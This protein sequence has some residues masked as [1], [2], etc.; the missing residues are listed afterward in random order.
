MSENLVLTKHKSGFY[1]NRSS[2]EEYSKLAQVLESKYKAKCTLATSGMNAINN[3][4][5]V[6]LREENEN[7]TPINLVY[8]NELY[9]DSPRLFKYL[10]TNLYTTYSVDVTESKSVITLFSE[11]CKDKINILFVEACTNPSGFIFDFSI[12]DNLR[13]LS[14]KLYVIVDN[15][16]L[17]SYIFN[18]LDHGADIVVT[19]LTKYYGNGSCIAGAI[20]TR[21]IELQDKLFDY[22]R[23]TGIHVSP[24]HCSLI[25]ENI[26]SL[27]QRIDK[28]SEL[29]FN[30]VQ[31]LTKR[32][33]VVT[34][35]CLENHPSNK[36]A[37][38]LF[39]KYPS[40]FTFTVKLSKNKTLKMMQESGIN[41]KTSFGSPDTRFDPWPKQEKG[42]ISCRLA[43]GHNDTFENVTKLLD[44]MLSK[45]KL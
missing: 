39:K 22:N 1:Y 16:W 8:G 17:T 28:S 41:F 29:T 45:Y 6:L 9:C 42:G 35:P 33:L 44:S 37:L 38:S 23:I 12:I 24:L 32:G 30:V 2:H 7:K 31:Y 20:L 3:V 15:T 11:K 36:L 27:E 21:D 4:L 19:S 40:V 13:K 5:Q 18:P 43:I 26:N 14:E 25:L 10:E 34:H